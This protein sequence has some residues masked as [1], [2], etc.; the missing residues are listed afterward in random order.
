MQIC[1]MDKIIKKIK[2]D[3]IE[4]LLKICSKKPKILHLEIIYLLGMSMRLMMDKIM[5]NINKKG[6]KIKKIILYQELISL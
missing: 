3:I 2:Q 4:K 1:Q 6:L 5:L